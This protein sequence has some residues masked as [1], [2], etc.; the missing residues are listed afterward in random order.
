MN[1][2]ELWRA[3]LRIRLAEE[4]VARMVESGEAGCPCH[5]YIGQ[6]AIAAGVCATLEARDT[7]WGG[8]R[9]HGH[10]LAKG[11]SLERMFAEILGRASGCSG[12]RGGSMHLFDREHGLLGT[13]PIVAA[14]V[15]LACGAAMAAKLRGSGEI[16]VAFLGDGA[17]E[18]GHVHESM[19]LAAVY[20]LPL[21]FVCENNLYSS[22]LHWRE[23]RA[24]DRLYR[25]GELHGMPAQR[26]DGN[27]AI[28]VSQ[29]AR[30]AVDGARSANG[31]SFVECRTF[32]WRGHVGASFDLDVGV[33]RGPELKEWM[34]RDPIARLEARLEAAKIAAARL[35][36]EREIGAALDRA[37]HAAEPAAARVMEY[38]F[39][40]RAACAS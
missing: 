5:L 22:H 26:V 34:T 38:V 23:R 20:R 7:I 17:M 19:N 21:I 10:Y 6:E 8:H 30:V 3:M 27:D 35:E 36:I 40:G 31:P 18:E 24:A 2:F 16:A 11:G 37:R 14:T 1:E 28:A 12:G 9:S 4:A 39:A 33:E 29:A 15:P 13:V 32:R 25:A